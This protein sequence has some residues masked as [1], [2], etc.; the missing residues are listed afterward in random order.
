[1]TRTEISMQR[2]S[3]NQL[4]LNTMPEVIIYRGNQIHKFNENSYIAY[5]MDR[6]GNIEDYERKTL[7][8]AQAVIDNHI[9]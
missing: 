8:G 7:E 2:E 6:Y 1:V 4:K 5:V 3:I 9:K